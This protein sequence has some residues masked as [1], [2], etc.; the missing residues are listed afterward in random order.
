MEFEA[1]KTES[2]AAIRELRDSNEEYK[3]V[4]ERLETTNVALEMERNELRASLDGKYNNLNA[5]KKVSASHSCIKAL[6]AATI[7]QGSSSRIYLGWTCRGIIVKP[8][9]R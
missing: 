2:D 9:L 5:L 4:N 6:R 7:M 1:I 8:G 3:L